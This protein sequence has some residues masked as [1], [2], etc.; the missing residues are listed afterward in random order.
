MQATSDRRLSF[1]PG[2]YDNQSTRP[3]LIRVNP[4]HVRLGPL[5]QINAPALQPILIASGL[6]DCRTQDCAVAAMRCISAVIV[7]AIMLLS[8]R[9]LSAAEI[10]TGVTRDQVVAILKDNGYRAEIVA[11]RPGSTPAFVRTG[12]AGH[13]VVVWFFDCAAETCS[14]IQF[15][16]GFQKSPKFSADL[17]E[18]WNS[19][20]RYAKLHLTKEG[21]LH[22]EYDVLLKG[23]VSS[24]YIKY[25]A[26]LDE[27]LLSRLD[28]YIR[29]APVADAGESA[30]KASDIDALAVQGKYTEAL[31]AVDEVAAALWDK[32]PLTMRRALWV[33]E[34]P[35]G[36]GRYNPRENNVFAS[37]VKMVIYAEPVGF[38]WRKNGDLWQTDVAIDVVV[39]GKDGAALQRAQDFTNLRI[40]SRVRNREMM[41]QLTY[42]FTGIPAGEYVVDSIMRDKVSGK[43]GTFSLPFV[44]R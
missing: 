22:V 8:A 43:T 34:P 5:R 23:G 13:T 19:E 31:A 10:V 6:K 21:E 4:G 40:G 29:T 37:G 33:A 14:A 26:L 36:F 16:T 24:D 7:S 39:K 27:S 2:K 11:G 32:A 44:V 1:I 30:G 12:I 38:G 41:A 15:W 25:A 17:V 35:T 3:S 20:F 42:S 9:S 18:R 28:E